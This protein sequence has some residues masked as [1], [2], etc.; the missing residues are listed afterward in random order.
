MVPY[1][2]KHISGPATE[3]VSLALLKEQ[4]KLEAADTSED[5]LL[6]QYL[7]SAR[8]DAENHL[9]L[10]IGTQTWDIFLDDWPEY[11]RYVVPLSPLQTVAEIEYTDEN[12]VAATLAT[13]VY[14]YSAARGTIWL[15]PGQSWPTV[16]LQP[17]GGV[18]IRVT[19][20]EQPR[21][22]GQTP[23]ALAYPQNWRQAILLR[24]ATYYRLREDVTTGTT[25]Q[26]ADVR[27]FQSLLGAERNFA[28]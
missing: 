5:V 8:R 16:K 22:D 15:K 26:S 14:G 25:M 12:A 17:S 23:A 13:T 4:V 18:R 21:S 3:P 10:M 1:S 24:A 19:V 20:G 7:A 28:I 27:A 6:E 9:G 11:C 2:L